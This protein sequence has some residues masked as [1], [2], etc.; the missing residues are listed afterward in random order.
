MSLNLKLT[1]IISFLKISIHNRNTFVKYKKNQ[2][3]VSLLECFLEN[4]FISGFFESEDFIYILL[5]YNSLG[6]SV[7]KDLKV[8]YKRP[9]EVHLTYSNL[10]SNSFYKKYLIKKSEK[11][12]LFILSTNKGIVTH[13]DAL[14]YGIG[15]QLLL[16]LKGY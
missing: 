2:L 14:N 4:G 16:V 15:G 3:L 13:K 10:K 9:F 1:K 12:L 6:E 7:I 5:K 11:S 8:L